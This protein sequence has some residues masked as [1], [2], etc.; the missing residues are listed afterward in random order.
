M[1]IEAEVR[2]WTS[3]AT[4]DTYGLFEKQIL[5]NL[6]DT[7]DRLFDGESKAIDVYAL[8]YATDKALSCTSLEV[9]L[10]TYEKALKK[11]IHTTTS[12]EGWAA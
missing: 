3:P 1:D 2:N 10:S 6:F 7:L 9:D 4:A 12:E 5:E 11:I 8:T